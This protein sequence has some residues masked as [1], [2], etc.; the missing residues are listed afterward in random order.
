MPNAPAENTV[1]TSFTLPRELLEIIEHRAKIEM[2]N[3]S[4][5]IR[6]ALMNY[7]TDDERAD[8][9]R[10]MHGAA[11]RSSKTAGSKAVSYGKAKTKK[12]P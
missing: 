7:L 5:L 6:R 3:R 12:A 1:S 4:E 2:T 8:V 9:L 10:E 11:S